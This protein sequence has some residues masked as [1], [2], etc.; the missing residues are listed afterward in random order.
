MVSHLSPERRDL[1]EILY[2]LDGL[3]LIIRVHGFYFVFIHIIVIV[4]YIVLLVLLCLLSITSNKPSHVTFYSSYLSFLIAPCIPFHL[5]IT[6]HSTIPHWV[7]SYFILIF[8]C[9]QKQYCYKYVVIVRKFLPFISLG[10]IPSSRTARSKDGCSLVIF[11]AQFQIAF[12]NNRTYSNFHQ[13][14]VH[15]AVFSKSLFHL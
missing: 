13:R 14:Y 2:S 11:L 9:H 5:H 15:R 4:M 12:Q 1:C 6:I 10:Y 8:F 7:V 3:L